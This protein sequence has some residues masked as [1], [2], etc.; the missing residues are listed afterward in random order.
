M[1]VLYIIIPNSALVV[2]EIQESVASALCVF[3]DLYVS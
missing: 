2:N 1:Y 3:R